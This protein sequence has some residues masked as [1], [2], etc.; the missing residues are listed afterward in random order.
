MR[1][2]V[3]CAASVRFVLKSGERR[4]LP[5]ASFDADF[6]RFEDACKL[7]SISAEDA[8]RVAA[9]HEALSLYRGAAAAG[10]V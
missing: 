9:L 7:A 3:G 1:Q 8:V 6:W 5:E 10:W 2:A 4:L